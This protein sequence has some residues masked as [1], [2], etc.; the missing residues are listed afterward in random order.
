MD[1]FKTLFRLVKP[2]WQRV[3]LA[4]LI[5]IVISGINASI[6][7]LVKPALDDVLVKKDI[8]LII[9]LPIGIFVIFIL[10]GVFTFF[11]EYLMRSA[12]QKMVMNLRNKLYSH[13]IQAAL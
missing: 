1:D 3:V 11:H 13:V 7:W 5:S 12:S 2:Y 10:R 8:T 6:A 9:L 4:G